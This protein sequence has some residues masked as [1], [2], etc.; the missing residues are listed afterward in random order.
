MK[1]KTKTMII[2]SIITLLPILLGL[3]MYD[4]LPAELPTHWGASG[5]I[6]DYSSRAFVVFGM[7]FLMLLFGLFVQFGLES[8]PKKANMSSTLKTIS[9]WICPVL[10]LIIVPISIF[11]G[12]GY[13]LPVELIICLFVGVM[14]ILMGNYMPKSKQTYTMG[15]R[16]PWTLNSEENWNRTHRLAGKLWILAGFMFI[17]TGIVSLNAYGE[18]GIPVFFFI[19]AATVFIPAIYSYILFKKG[20]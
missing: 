5:E 10:S 8:D 13:D 7:P 15:I 2:T 14:F 4:K 12:I 1:N 6:D 11:T 18:V 9:F 20:I 16:L 17:V 19:I 3:A